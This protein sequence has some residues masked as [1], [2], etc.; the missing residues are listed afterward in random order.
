MIFWKIGPDS[1]R[2][3]FASKID[4][5]C[6]LFHPFAI[7][8][9]IPLEEA[10]AVAAAAAAAPASENR[11]QVIRR[12][13]YSISPSPTHIWLSKLKMGGQPI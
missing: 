6:S 7:R 10:A 5:L 8:S 4:H 13:V 3:P 9:A 12:H 1:S 2:V 11:V